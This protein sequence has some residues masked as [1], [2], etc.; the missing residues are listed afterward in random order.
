[1][2]PRTLSL[3]LLAIWVGAMLGLSSLLAPNL[4]ERTPEF[5]MDMHR[6]PAYGAFEPNPIFSDGRTLRAPVEG[7]VARGYMPFPYGPGESEARRAGLELSN[8]LPDS[9]E[10]A[11]RGRFV[12]AAICAVCHG[13]GGLGDG[14]V[15]RRGVPPPPS[16]LAEQARSLRD[17][18]IY[19]IIT[20]GRKNMASHAAIVRRDDRWAVIRHIRKLQGDAR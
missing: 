12:F 8:P 17:G 16:L 3:V 5:L 10:I 1:M 15:T 2:S 20:Y 19:H 7:S 9:P 13:A 6:S 11:E 18:E 4:E 14:P